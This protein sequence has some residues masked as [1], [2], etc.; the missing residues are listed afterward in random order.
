[1]AL[2]RTRCLPALDNEISKTT[3]EW[4]SPLSELSWLKPVTDQ[5]R[6][7]FVAIKEEVNLSFD[8]HVLFV[9]IAE[10]LKTRSLL[11]PSISESVDKVL[12]FFGN[13]QAMP[14]YSAFPNNIK[15]VFEKLAEAVDTWLD[16]GPDRTPKEMELCL[17]YLKAEIKT[18]TENITSVEDKVSQTTTPL[19]DRIAKAHSAFIA[20]LQTC[21]EKFKGTVLGSSYSL[22]LDGR[23]NQGLTCYFRFLPAI[24]K[25]HNHDSI[26]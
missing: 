8:L 10:L 3:S 18:V 1:M 22:P 12:A 19:G 16:L 11:P 25:F 17:T 4:A 24:R 14:D 9:R 6:T 15:S 13:I 26:D 21:E 5:W 20:L 2:L 7:E 23:A